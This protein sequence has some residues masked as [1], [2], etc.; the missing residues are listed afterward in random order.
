MSFAGTDP[1]IVLVA[2]PVRAA[3]RAGHHDYLAGCR[4]FAELLSRVP[5]VTTE[6]VENGWP[7][8]E[9]SLEQAA[10]IVFYD[11]GGGKQ[12]FLANAERRALIERQAERGCGLVLLHQAAGFPTELCAWGQR[13]FGAVYEAGVSRR[14]H[15]RVRL[16]GADH[17]IARA[18]QS[19]AIRDGWLDHA[20]LPADRVDDVT[21][22]LWPDD[23]PTSD[24]ERRHARMVAWAYEPPAG[25]RGFVF[26][27]AD[28]HRL[29]RDDGARR[30]VASGMLWSAGI[31]APASREWHATSDAD[32]DSRRSPRQS[33]LPRLAGK[34]GRR[35]RRSLRGQRKW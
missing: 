35:V 33:P 28:N 8:D 19:H 22:L 14:G 3:G 27:G 4:L 9:Q 10:S 6:V 32:V 30:F 15:R 13:H 7:T 26:T 34:L 5:G 17:P 23:V 11:N 21:P 31:A 18:W 25:G 1:H 24:R 20:A 12:G 2:G 16:Q 29:W